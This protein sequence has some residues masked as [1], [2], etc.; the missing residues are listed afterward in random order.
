MDSLREM[1]WRSRDTR[2]RSEENRRRQ[3]TAPRQAVRA[4]TERG[5]N[6][7]GY[8]YWPLDE[9]QAWLPRGPV[10]GDP[11]A[12]RGRRRRGELQP[13]ERHLRRRGRLA[14][15]RCGAE[16]LGTDH[17]SRYR[18]YVQKRAHR[19]KSLLL[20]GAYSA[21]DRGGHGHAPV[22]NRSA[23]NAGDSS[24]SES[25]GTRSGRRPR[26]RNSSKSGYILCNSTGFIT[27][28]PST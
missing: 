19:I 25:S 15:S 13:S 8:R 22:K 28:L 17:C 12:R 24:P 10:R 1:D 4:G 6:R 23:Q 26:K 16:E 7:G 3:F 21:R 14:F 27:L 18:S 9:H 11:Q 2:K 20:R 5:G